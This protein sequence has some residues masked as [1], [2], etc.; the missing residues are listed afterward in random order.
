VSGP[1]GIIFWHFHKGAEDSSCFGRDWNREAY[2]ISLHLCCYITLLSYSCSYV[3]SGYV[4][5]NTQVVLGNVIVKR[6]MKA[7]LSFF[8][9]SVVLLEACD[10]V[11]VGV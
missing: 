1:I 4:E 11:R 3:G 7:W 9:F 10:R 6:G 8:H 2:N 5:K